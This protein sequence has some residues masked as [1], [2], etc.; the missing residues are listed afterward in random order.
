M[1]PLSLR[2]LMLYKPSHCIICQG[3]CVEDLIWRYCQVHLLFLNVFFCNSDRFSIVSATFFQ[4]LL[5][6]TH[7]YPSSYKLTC[8]FSVITASFF[9]VFTAHF[10]I[11]LFTAPKAVQP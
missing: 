10:L 8:L 4:V 7:L 1:S 3:A 2:I 11:L 6:F 9:S 5:N